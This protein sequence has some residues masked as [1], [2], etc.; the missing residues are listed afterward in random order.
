MPLSLTRR[1]GRL[2][3]RAL[4]LRCVACGG[5]PIFTSWFRMLP[6]CTSCG[7]TFER[8]ERGYWLG[9]YFVNIMLMET[10]FCLWFVGVISWT[11]PVMRWELMQTGITVLMVVTPFLCHPFS[12]TLF[13]AFDLLVRPPAEPDFEA[14]EERAA[15]VRPGI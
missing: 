12:K 2:A 10:V 13:V 5:R 3:W 14:P 6:N 8:G 4:R 1:A 9:A 11:Y 7:F 15:R